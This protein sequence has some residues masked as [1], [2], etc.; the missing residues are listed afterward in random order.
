MTLNVDAVCVIAVVV[1]TSNAP[2]L[3]VDIGGRT[4][5]QTDANGNAHVRVQL[6]R[7]VRQLSVS[8]GT[9]TELAL[10]PQNPSRLFELDGRD[11]I[12]LVEQ[13]FATDRRRDAKRSVTRMN[14]VPKH[15]LCRVGSP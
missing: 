13:S 12:L 15:V 14:R 7:E 3:P 5:G 10:R 11:A 1:H 6:E 4:V 2:S 9:R 8:L